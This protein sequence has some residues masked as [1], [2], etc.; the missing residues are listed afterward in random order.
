MLFNGQ[1]YCVNQLDRDFKF[2][3]MWHTAPYRKLDVTNSN[4]VILAVD[5][6][7][8]DMMP[9]TIDGLGLSK[10]EKIKVV[11]AK[12]YTKQTLLNEKE[13]L[14]NQVKRNLAE[15][16][17]KFFFKTTFKQQRSFDDAHKAVCMTFLKDF[18]NALTELNKEIGIFNRQN[19]LLGNSAVSLIDISK[20]TY[21]KAQKIVNMTMKQLYCFD[22]AKLY[23]NT[24]FKFCHIAIDSF[25]LD[26][27]CG[28]CKGKPTWSNLTPKQY[29][30]LQTKF[31]KQWNAKMK[32]KKTQFRHLF[33]AEF[34]IWQLA[35]DS[36]ATI[37]TLIV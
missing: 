15:N 16:I 34:V 4:D 26:F 35:K 13:K 5:N 7:Y 22:N 18:T 21:G 17:V 29:I 24:V 33:F 14:L 9:R 8:R 30:F 20:I 28:N 3:V 1:Q 11:Q 23:K 2:F 19:M 27:F 31:R 32:G 37:K 6:A 36:N 10:L 25:I 12:S